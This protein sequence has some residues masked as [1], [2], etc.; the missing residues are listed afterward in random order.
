M[1]RN[2]FSQSKG[3]A[4]YTKVFTRFL[5]PF[6][7]INITPLTAVIRAEEKEKSTH[8]SSWNRAVA[9]GERQEEEKKKKERGGGII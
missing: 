3:S 5:Y 6:K 4:K 9:V 7:D 8:Y 2:A 1:A